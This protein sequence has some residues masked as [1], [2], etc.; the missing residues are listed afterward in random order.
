MESNPE[1]ITSTIHFKNQPK[2]SGSEIDKNRDERRLA[3][4]S[5]IENFLLNDDLF[6][7]K[8]IEVEFS[9]EGIS[10]LVCFIEGGDKKM[11]LKI[12]LGNTVTEG[13]EALFLR[14]WESIGISTPHIYKD[15]K[16]AGMPLV[17]MEYIDA[18]TAGEKYKE[19]K[20][21]REI[22]HFEAGRILREMHKPEAIG[23]GKVID[24]KGEYSSF[25]EWIDTP[26]M[27]NRVKYIEENRNILVDY[28]DDSNKSSYCHFDYSAGHLFATEPLTVFD[29]NPLFNNGYI[30]LG[31]TLVNYI[32]VSGTYPKQL[33]EGYFEEGGLDEKVLHASIFINIIYKLPY[34]HQKGRSQTI[35]NFQNYLTQNKFL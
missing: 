20:E 35:Q 3:L 31:R 12:A 16:L 28:V 9:H 11:V 23:F 6:R 10:S 27:D 29:P 25:K 15:G 8:E 18:P 22:M 26:D 19:N 21:G 30:D 2:L 33:V 7:G 1:K 17:L 24:G 32:A 14:T 4:V 5:S 13:S 34:Q